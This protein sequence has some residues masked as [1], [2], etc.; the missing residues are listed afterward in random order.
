VRPYDGQ[1]KGPRRAVR[2]RDGRKAGSRLERLVLREPAEQAWKA[3]D[4]QVNGALNLGPH[5]FDDGDLEDETGADLPLASELPHLVE[6]RDLDKD[7]ARQNAVALRVLEAARRAGWRAV[8]VDD[9]VDLLGSSP[10]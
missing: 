3:F 8:A 6:V 5:H 9:M 10:T 7:Y 1:R 4:D 2:L